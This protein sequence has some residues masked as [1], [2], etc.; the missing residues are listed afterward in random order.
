LSSEIVEILLQ[1]SG[2]K[3]IVLIDDQRDELGRQ[4]GRDDVIRDLA[5]HRIE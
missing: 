2:G 1:D 5:G 4:V 3:E